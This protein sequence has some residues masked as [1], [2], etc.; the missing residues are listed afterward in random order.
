[1]DQREQLPLSVDLALAAQREAIE[2]LV[3]AQVREHRFDGGKAATVL[4]TV[5]NNIAGACAEAPTSSL[6]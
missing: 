2:P 3:V 5:F 1:M 4:L 6:R